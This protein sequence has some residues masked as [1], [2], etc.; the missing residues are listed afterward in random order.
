MAYQRN[1]KVLTSCLDSMQKTPDQMIEPLSAAKAR[2]KGETETQYGMKIAT[3]SAR[4]SKAE[5]IKT[6]KCYNCGE[7]GHI[8]KT[9]RKPKKTNKTSDGKVKDSQEQSKIHESREI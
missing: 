1:M 6:A 2:M 7:V 3:E 5:W 9:C 8:K 4:R